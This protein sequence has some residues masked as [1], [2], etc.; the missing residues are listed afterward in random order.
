MAINKTQKFTTEELEELSNIQL[1]K[2]ESNLKN[3]LTILEKKEIEIANKLTEKY[4]KGS[5]NIETGEFTP[6]E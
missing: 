3:Q 4:G 2:E 1:E 5:L 6:I